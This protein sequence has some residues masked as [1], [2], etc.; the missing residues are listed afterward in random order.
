MKFTARRHW[1]A[2]LLMKPEFP[3]CDDA[4]SKLPLHVMRKGNLA[5][6]AARRAAAFGMR[7]ITWV[8]RFVN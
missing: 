8:C 7:H 5:R 6:P 1:R 3:R 2:S 4:M